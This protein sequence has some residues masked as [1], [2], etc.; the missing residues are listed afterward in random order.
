MEGVATPGVPAHEIFVNT[1]SM[2]KGVIAL[3]IGGVNVPPRREYEHLRVVGQPGEVCFKVFGRQWVYLMDH[4]E[5]LNG[6]SIEEDQ[7][8]GTCSSAV[9][10]GVSAKDLPGELQSKWSG[11]EASGATFG[12]DGASR[13]RNRPVAFRGELGQERGLPCAWRTS[14]DDAWHG[15]LN[16]RCLP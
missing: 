14:D 10:F 11:T 13:L 7:L 9:L 4:C 12:N 8:P 5:R 6:C 2:F 15:L 3:G 16:L 1:L